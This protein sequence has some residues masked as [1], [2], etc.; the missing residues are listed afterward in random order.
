MFYRFNKKLLKS[1]LRF[2]LITALIHIGVLFIRAIKEG[3]IKILNK[4]N[5]FS[6]NKVN[7]YNGYEIKILEGKKIKYTVS[8][9]IFDLKKKTNY[10]SYEEYLGNNFILGHEYE[11][12][13]KGLNYSTSIEELDNK[14]INKNGSIIEFEIKLLNEDYE[15]IKEKI[16]FLN[17][18]ITKLSQRELNCES[19]LEENKRYVINLGY[20]TKVQVFGNEI[21]YFDEDT[22]SLIKNKDEIYLLLEDIKN[23]LMKIIKEENPGQ[24]NIFR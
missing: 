22:E 13:P 18:K 17:L 24:K 15:K 6:I 2:V 8:K 16:E 1:F 5:E 7:L 4:V 9:K 14:K 11:N 10:I 3:D 20:V 21:A 12:K 19:F 23:D